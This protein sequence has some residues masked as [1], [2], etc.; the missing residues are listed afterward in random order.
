MKGFGH[1]LALLL[2]LAILGGCSNSGS[3]ML[4]AYP[5]NGTPEFNTFANHCSQ[6]H[7]PPHPGTHVAVEWSPVVARMRQHMVQ[8]GL[9][10]VTATEQESILHYLEAHAKVNR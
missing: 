9:R 4:A 7:A 2:S 3:S 6:C 1:A 8:R 10:D 5:D